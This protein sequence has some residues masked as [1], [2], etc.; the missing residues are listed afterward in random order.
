MCTS[1]Y[2]ETLPACAREFRLAAS[3][4]KAASDCRASAMDTPSASVALRWSGVSVPA[5]VHRVRRRIAT[6][7]R[8]SKL[9]AVLSEF[10]LTGVLQLHGPVQAQAM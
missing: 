5:G 4:V 7:T 9:A 6:G 3:A 2:A 10:K 1:T 8:C